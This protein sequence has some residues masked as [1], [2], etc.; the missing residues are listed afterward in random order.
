MAGTN[1]SLDSNHSF[2]L[3]T[4]RYAFKT[5]MLSVSLVEVFLLAY[6]GV[7]MTEHLCRCFMRD[8]DCP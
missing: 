8:D 3:L 4:I 7:L 2:Q 6:V 1:H 5:M